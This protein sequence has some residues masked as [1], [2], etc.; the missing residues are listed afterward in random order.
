[1]ACILTSSLFRRDTYQR[2]SIMD[3]EDS[4]T[5]SVVIDTIPSNAPIQQPDFNLPYHTWYITAEQVKA[6]TS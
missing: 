2:H 5:S 3:R 6:H 4:L 1:M